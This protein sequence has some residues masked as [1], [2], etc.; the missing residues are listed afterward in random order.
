MRVELCLL[1]YEG[2]FCQISTTPSS[3]PQG[4]RDPPAYSPLPIPNPVL[5]NENELPTYSSLNFHTTTERDKS[6]HSLGELVEDVL[7]FVDPVQD[8]I[9]SLSLRY[10]VP[11]DAL[12]RTNSLFANNLLSARRTILIP[13]EY[14]KGGVSLSSRPIE[15]EEEWVKKFKIRRWM[16]ACKVAE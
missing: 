13:G 7:H 12:R 15:G 8:T 4:L 16:V 10:G 11:Q 6:T 2:P 3:L 5:P 14:Y 1:K 9:P